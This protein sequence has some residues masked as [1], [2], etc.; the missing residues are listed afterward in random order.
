M[1]KSKVKFIEKISHARYILLQKYHHKKNTGYGR[2]SGE[3]LFI[4]GKTN[5]ITT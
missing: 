1:K 3:S 2:L 5:S 4:N